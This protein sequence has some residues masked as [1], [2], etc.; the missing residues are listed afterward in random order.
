MM[1]DFTLPGLH[2]LGSAYNGLALFIILK[3]VNT[4]L[5]NA[6]I[7]LKPIPMAPECLKM[8]VYLLSASNWSKSEEVMS[9]P[10]FFH[11]LCYKFPQILHRSYKFS[12]I[13]AKWA[14]NSW[15]SKKI[16]RCINSSSKPLFPNFWAT[17]PT[18]SPIDWP[19]RLG[20]YSALLVVMLGGTQPRAGPHVG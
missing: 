9:F 17:C 7:A 19:H 6:Q 14:P 1:K 20:P 5:Y 10:S 13:F 2:H 8:H 16:C 12:W 11:Y 18:L 15:D 4:S 3:S